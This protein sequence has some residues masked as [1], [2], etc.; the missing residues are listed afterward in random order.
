M[1]DVIIV[2]GGHNGLVAANLLAGAGLD[3]TVLEKNERVGG[4]AFTGEFAPGLRFAQC[5]YSL[6]MMPRP[7]MERLGVWPWPKRLQGGYFAPRADGGHLRLPLDGASR[8]AELAA[9]CGARDLAAYDRYEDWIVRV[10]RLVQ[11]WIHYT[12]R[13]DDGG[14][15]Y[16]PGLSAE[17]RTLMEE[18]SRTS[19]GAILDEGFRSAVRGFDVDPIASDPLKGI[20]A[21]SASIGTRGPYSA[22]S[23]FSVLNLQG[24]WGFPVGGMGALSDA[25]AAGAERHGAR[26]RVD[27]PV[28]RITVSGGRATGVVLDDDAGTEIAADFVVT[29]VDPRLSYL[30]LLDDE[31]RAELGAAF[32]DHV[33]GLPC[34]GGTVKVNL[35]LDGR[36]VP[37]DFTAHPEWLPDAWRDTFVLAESMTEVARA[38]RDAA[39]GRPAAVPM[40][41]VGLLS[42]G[43]DDTLVDQERYPGWEVVS[44]FCQSVPDRFAAAP[45]RDEIDAFARRVVDRLDA[46]I[47]GFASHVRFVDARGPWQIQERTGLQHGNIYGVPWSWE[48]RLDTTTAVDGLIDASSGTHHGGCVNGIPGMHAADAV[49]GALG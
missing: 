3:V 43:G 37:R 4:A 7:L 46:V 15:R 10:N 39:E 17:G 22:E 20:K 49:I 12:R 2:G 44:A 23:V 36:V 11:P 21:V 47:P 35:A 1:H 9:K 41:D 38:F 5:S 48:P 8:S 33:R 24:D 25:L 31:G 42:A 26:V 45:H 6:G 18:L 32:V 27:A 16:P 28:A 34:S 30:T 40:V 29:A 13:D 19:V 14:I